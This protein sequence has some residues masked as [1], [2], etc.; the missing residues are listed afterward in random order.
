MK[1]QII[2]VFLFLV[3]LSSFLLLFGI[4]S[5]VCYRLF[6]NRRRKSSLDDFSI[7]S[8]ELHG[9][10]TKHLPQKPITDNNPLPGLNW[11]ALA[12]LSG[13]SYEQ[14][15]HES[16]FSVESFG[17]ILERLESERDLLNST[18]QPMSGVEDSILSLPKTPEK[19]DLV[20]SSIFSGGTICR[21]NH[22]LNQ[23]REVKRNCADI[24]QSLQKVQ[25]V[26]L[27]LNL[28][29]DSTHDELGSLFEQSFPPS[30]SKINSST[31]SQTGDS[32]SNSWIFNQPKSG[33]N[34]AESSR[35]DASNEIRLDFDKSIFP[36]ETNQS[37]GLD[38]SWFDASVLSDK[39]NNGQP[40]TKVTANCQDKQNQT[41]EEDILNQDSTLER[42]KPELLIASNDSQEATQK[43]QFSKQYSFFLD[44]GMT[45][46]ISL[47]A[48][49]NNEEATLEWDSTDV[50]FFQEDEADDELLSKPILKESSFSGEKSFGQFGQSFHSLSCLKNVSPEISSIE[51]PRNDEEFFDYSPNDSFGNSFLQLTS[52]QRLLLS[53][54][55][56]RFNQIAHQ[57]PPTGNWS[58]SSSMTSSVCSGSSTTVEHERSVQHLVEEAQKLGLVRDLLVR[59]IQQAET[60]CLV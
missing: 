25:L 15:Q 22:L 8:A 26:I 37:I 45:E 13:L 9:D 53:D 30:E 39:T 1:N 38:N 3:R 33:D 34:F 24:D 52:E 14:H 7:N 56:R 36:N 10:E 58:A 11:S 44:D 23:I 54:L 4:G 35:I 29:E 51:R 55:S 12:E 17:K 16:D 2:I 6:A 57:Q 41:S 47:P 32:K 21:L 49:V 27:P 46:K 50:I 60:E 31:T 59:L 20:N 48:S 18:Q 43:T 42:L 5:F 40:L 19:I 28:S